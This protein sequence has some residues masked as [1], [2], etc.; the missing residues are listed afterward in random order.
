MNDKSLKILN[1][2]SKVKLL[3]YRKSMTI[4]LKKFLQPVKFHN[5][6][7]KFSN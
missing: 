7:T 3:D 6:E 4:R 5:K 2:K 1:V